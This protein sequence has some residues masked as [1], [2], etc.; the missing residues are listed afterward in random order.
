MVQCSN[1]SKPRS[2]IIY[3]E[4]GGKKTSQLYHLAKYLIKKYKKKIRLISADGGGWAPFEDPCP[5]PFFEGNSLIESGWVDPFDISYRKT[6]LADVRR[7]SEGY[8]PRDSK[9]Y[10][11]KGYLASDEKCLTTPEEWEGIIGYMVEGVY[12]IAMMWL[13]HIAD[14]EGG[15]GF[16]HSYMYKED[17]YL[18]GGLQEGH[19]G[20]VQ[21]E[22][23]KVIVHGFNRLPVKFNIWTSLVGKGKNKKNNP[24][25][26]DTSEL[27]Y[28]PRSAGDAT[29][30][31][32]PSWFMDCIHIDKQRIE[33]EDKVVEKW[34]A[35]FE[36]HEDKDT[37]IPYLAKARINSEY[38]PKLL[39][40]FP[41]GFVELGYKNG[42]DK[43][44]REMD[45]IKKEVK[46]LYLASR[47]ERKEAV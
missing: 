46:D 33:K 11:E 45:R 5:D 44:L 1:I 41:G 29:T 42:L 38:Y 14:Q 35:W 4:S 19:Y 8:W 10:G 7:L 31:E 16:K 3:A 43:Y 12:S 9:K 15:V 2:M 20:I 39:E 32:I 13:S 21:K 36:E 25:S 34:V 26:S 28:G 23:R 30:S 17:D 37:E 24:K 18:I 40:K 47:K 27:C 6:A 22:I